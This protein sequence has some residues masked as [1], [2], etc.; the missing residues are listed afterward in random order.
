MFALYNARHHTIKHFNRCKPKLTPAERKARIIK[1][2]LARA[3]PNLFCKM[4]NT[5]SI[6]VNERRVRA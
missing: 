4:K 5:K 1:K 2:K 3:F 6:H